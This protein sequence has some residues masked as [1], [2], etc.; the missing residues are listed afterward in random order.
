MFGKTRILLVLLAIVAMLQGCGKVAPELDVA[1]AKAKSEHCTISEDIS[2]VR[3]N[4]MEYILHK[5]DETM[6]DGI[7]TKQHSFTECINCH[8]PKGVGDQKVRHDEEEHFCATCHMY[9]GVKLDC[10]Q[11]HT[12]QPEEVVET[13]GVAQ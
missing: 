7:R 2:E 8:V 5:R 11:C 3:N 13:A 4:H 6:Y 1:T 9:T 10:F 12:D